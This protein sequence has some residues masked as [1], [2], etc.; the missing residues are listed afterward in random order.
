[1][2]V[3]A[4]CCCPCP[5]VANY[6]ATKLAEL[7][8][9]LCTHEVGLAPD[10]QQ[11]PANGKQYLELTCNG[12]VRFMCYDVCCYCRSMLAILSQL[13]ISSTHS[14]SCAKA[15]RVGCWVTKV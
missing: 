10:T 13:S 1:M 6:C 5:Q 7:G 8:V 14:S 3:G 4:T 12:L 15:C 11:P 2:A 9:P